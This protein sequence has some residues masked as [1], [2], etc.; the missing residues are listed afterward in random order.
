MCRSVMCTMHSPAVASGAIVNT[1]VVMTSRTGRLLRRAPVEDHPPR[2]VA[3]RED[4]DER[5]ALHHE[6]RPH[7]LLLEEPQGVEH[8]RLRVDRVDVGLPG[9]DLPNGRHRSLPSR[10][11]RSGRRG[12]AVRSSLRFYPAQSFRARP[13][14]RHTL[15]RPPPGSATPSA[16]RPSCPGPGRRH[17]NCS[18]RPV[19]PRQPVRSPHGCADPR[20]LAVRD[21]HRLPLLLRAPHPR[22]RLGG[23][24]PADRLVRHRRRRSGSASRSSGASSSSSTSRWASSPGSCRSSS[25][26]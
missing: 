15:R 14:G 11:R 7:V 5:R 8:G 4:A 20:T 21:H 13:P 16:G 2:V 25:S 17:T 10:R 9:Q 3:L 1:S 26:A 12:R 19:E 6:Q 24:D 22:P 23:R 18:L